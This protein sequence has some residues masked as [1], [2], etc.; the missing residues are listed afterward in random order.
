MDLGLQGQAVVLDLAPEPLL[1]A[2]AR[3]CLEE[4]AAPILV[5][6]GDGAVQRTRHGLARQFG[7]PCRVLPAP[8]LKE[9][10]PGDWARRAAGPAPLAGVAIAVA[11]DYE[12]RASPWW[13]EGVGEAPVFNGLSAVLLCGRGCASEALPPEAV[14]SL[15]LAGFRT[16]VVELA[17]RLGPGPRCAGEFARAAGLVVFLMS[18]RS[19]YLSGRIFSADPAAP[20]VF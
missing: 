19:A 7:L 20:N 14:S 9:G 4:G 2:T 3:A 1:K 11:G 13:R 6:R 10:T 18:S 5:D 15:L 16:N 8:R 17:G 12:A